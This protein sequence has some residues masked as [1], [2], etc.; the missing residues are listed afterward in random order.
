MFRF[1]FL[2]IITIFLCACSSPEEEAIKAVKYELIDEDSA[3]FR[4]V[5]GK[6]FG[7]CGEV[8]SKN[9]LG[10]Y[11]GFKKF[12]YSEETNKK[13]EGSLVTYDESLVKILCSE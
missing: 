12:H 7:V 10:A 3:K 1:F 5:E 6:V 11:T 9:R 13:D 8:N 4:N 2:S